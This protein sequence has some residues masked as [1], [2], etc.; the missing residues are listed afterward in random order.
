MALDYL[1][2][3][4]QTAS[5]LV[6]TVVL[7]APAITRVAVST[8]TDLSNPFYMSVTLDTNNIGKATFSGLSSNTTY[9]YGVELDGVLNATRG[10]IPTLPAAGQPANFTVVVGACSNTGNLPVYDRMAEVD[11]VGHIHMGDRFYDDIDTEDQ[12]LYRTAY[13]NHHRQSKAKAF[14]LS[15]AGAE[16]SYIPDD[17]DGWGGNNSGGN[18][19]GRD[20]CAAVYRQIVP[21]RPLVNNTGAM[22]HLFDIGRVRFIVPDLRYFRDPESAVDTDTHTLL[23]ATQ[24]Q[25]LLDQLTIAH[26][27]YR[28]GHT[29]LVSSIVWLTD[30]GTTSDSWKRYA[31]E[32]RK[33]SKHIASLG[34]P[35]WLSMIAGDAH[36]CAIDSGANNNWYSFD[37][38]G[39]GFP[40]LQS[41]PIVGVGDSPGKGGPF[42]IGSTTTLVQHSQYS[43]VDV[44]D[45]GGTI[46]ITWTC[47]QVDISTG[48]QTIVVG[49]YSFTNALRPQVPVF[50]QGYAIWWDGIAWR[51]TKP[52]SDESGGWT[53][54]ISIE[55]AQ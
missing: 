16:L 22:Y 37:I 11:A 28:I 51:S 53:E 50:K 14:Y 34:P 9:H 35:G 55:I 23:G 17:H 42:D 36:R 38:L 10:H 40:T 27:D 24:L 13:A 20:S 43:T 4:G 7:T 26:S 19:P 1:L 32:R 45:S 52:E 15:K 49:P 44:S 18:L 3:G 30:E 41:A 6:I 31:K 47:Y 54:T 29:V 12:S 2:A 46:T 39:P 5:T 25:W 8:A 48:V 33:I 21:H